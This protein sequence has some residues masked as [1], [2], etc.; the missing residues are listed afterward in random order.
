M[1]TFFSTL[2][3]FKD[4]IVKI[5]ASKQKISFEFSV[6]NLL[7]LLLVVGFFAITI[8]YLYPQMSLFTGLDIVGNL[9]LAR[10][11]SLSPALFSSVSPSFLIYQATMYT[12]SISSAEL[13]QV[14]MAF[15]SVSVL[16]SFYVMA[17][18][19]LD[20]ID[21]RLSF[22]ATAFW[23]LF[24]G[25]GWIYL[26]QNKLEQLSTTQNSLFAKAYDATY[27][28]V[29]YGLSSNLWLWFIAMTASFS[30]F[31]TLLYLLKCKNIPR[32]LFIP[33]ISIL[34]ITLSFM[35][36]PELVMFALLMVV[37]AFLGPRNSLRVDEALYSTLIALFGTIAISYFVP[38][39]FGGLSMAFNFLV[40]GL[41]GLVGLTCLFK[42]L[43]RNNADVNKRSKS[44]KVLA[45]AFLVFFMAGVLGWFPSAATFSMTSVSNIFLVPWFFYP[46]RL[47]IIGFFGLLGIIIIA[48]KY[49][50]NALFVFPFLFFTAWIFGRIISF[51]NVNLF[52]TN[53]YEWRFLFF[54]FAA[55]SITSTLLLKFLQQKLMQKKS[56]RRI[57]LSAFLISL[58][59]LVGISSTFLTIEKWSQSADQNALDENELNA[60]LFLSSNLSSSQLPPLLTVTPQSVKALEFVP[61]TWLEK[62]I[63]PVIWA[64]KSSEIPLTFL[65]NLRFSPTTIYLNQRDLAV[66]N[67]TDLQD[68][69]LGEFLLQL[70]KQVYSNSE[71]KIYQLSSGV[72]PLQNGGSVLVFDLNETKNNDLFASY[73]LSLGGY[74]YTTMLSSDPQ[75][76]EHSTL[77]FPSDLM[78]SADLSKLGLDNGQKVIILNSDGYGQLARLFLG[79]EG[80]EATIKVTTGGAFV[81]D[82]T[83]K[84]LDLKSIREPMFANNLEFV[85]YNNEQNANYSSI[86]YDDQTAFWSVKGGLG[87]GNISV[88]LL[89]NDPSMKIEGNDS[90]KV[91]IGEGNYG[92]W[93]VEKDYPV[94]QDWSQRDFM[95]IWW[96]GTNSG[97][98]IGILASET[99]WKND[100]QYSFIDNFLGWQRL[101]VSLNEFT[102]YGA[103]SWSAISRLQ[104][105][106]LNGGTPGTLHIGS[107]GLEDGNNALMEITINNATVAVPKLSVFS[108]SAYMPITLP[109]VN[110]SN[111]IPG[112]DIYFTDGSSADKIFG[113]GYSGGAIMEKIND[114]YTIILS[115]KLSP[116]DSESSQCQFRVDYEGE[117]VYASSLITSKTEASLPM[118]TQLFP[119]TQTDGT[120]VLGWYTN[121]T[122]NVPLIAERMIGNQTELYYLNVYPIISS[123]L[124]N[125][126]SSQNLSQILANVFDILGLPKYDKSVPSWVI[127]DNNPVFAFKEGFLQGNTSIHADSLIPS[128]KLGLPEVCISTSNGQTFL[129]DVTS[130]SV[131]NPG[132]KIAISSQNVT[133]E[134]GIGFY[135]LMSIDS[136]QIMITGENILI[137]AMT[138]NG[139]YTNSQSS[140]TAEISINGSLS[141]YVDNPIIQTVGEAYFHE[142]YAFHSYLG[143]LQ[144]MGTDL[145]IKGE[146]NFSLILSDEY[147]I[148]SNFTWTG[149]TVRGYPTFTWNELASIQKSFLYF[150]LAI[151]IFSIAWI[152]TKL[153]LESNNKRLKRFGVE[154]EQG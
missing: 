65:N 24:S 44:I 136:A 150:V 51:V 145:T 64:S 90:L 142:A 128:E 104:L 49:S 127:E 119:F 48:N 34:V 68:S 131:Q 29:G 39:I 103:P 5:E 58:L 73:L 76:S 55:V 25:F 19:Y 94:A 135:T 18:K 85:M 87:T 26:F 138:S 71:V 72:P 86:V 146:T 124:A 15:T 125:A 96:Y 129:K 92:D 21:T 22:F 36:A 134:N 105:R 114:T 32:T 130:L 97:Q 147:S 67:S 75:I 116:K 111:E 113:K 143:S 82:I 1:I 9:T 78:T 144:T 60:I 8:I 23:A 66:L 81:Y 102:P 79:G 33:L 89:T 100:F 122:T 38:T 40:M 54:S 14:F 118:E 31:F 149:S 95:S 84:T 69:Y 154:N 30:I 148:A 77:I 110:S 61:S 6:V 101:I 137:S 28:D 126:N 108:G 35:H 120:S 107:I 43:K 37:L 45:Y 17:K 3:I 47:G 11:F 132:G 141:T 121:N 16:L 115:V 59:V 88:P 57:S 93:Y 99:S 117:I 41:A 74:N 151:I 12:V 10:L 62:N 70:I 80:N 46:V 63:Q 123:A 2:P 50:E 98:N 27:A 4:R 153:I 91:V 13:Y 42:F 109:S 133:V 140:K 112:H 106:S 20:E 7:T 53:Y 52:N 83:N 152:S 139:T 56:W